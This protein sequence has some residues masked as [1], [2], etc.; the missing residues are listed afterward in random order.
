MSVGLDYEKMADKIIELTQKI[1]IYERT[2]K[3]NNTETKSFKDLSERQFEILMALMI[4]K[5]SSISEMAEIMYVSRSTLSI[6]VS[7][8]I[9]KGYIVKNIPED[10]M[11]KRKTIFSLSQ[12]GINCLYKFRQN[13]FKNFCILYNSFDEREKKLLEEGIDKLF[14][15][16]E[17]REEYMNDK[18]MKSDIIQAI[19]E[20]DNEL[21]KMNIK[22]AIFVGVF[23]K[24]SRDL[25]RNIFDLNSDEK[26]ITKNQ[27]YIMYCIYYFEHNTIS[28]LEKFLNS[29]GSTVS[30][31]V[32][33]LVTAGYLKK[34]YPKFN[35]DGRAVFIKL[36]N[37]GVKMLNMVHTRT[38]E[39]FINFIERLDEEG[40]QNFNSAI[41]CLLEVFKV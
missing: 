32:S 4:M 20:S 39:A 26:P 21:E 36:T 9:K 19:L 25:C 3:K 16:F 15:Y 29:S 17:F 18:F 14:S 24:A 5:K 7:K 38:K 13:N 27:F 35:D 28:K 23:F 41:D 22:M 37:K 11:D 2:C 8:L 30:I 6:I 10:G 12:E 31:T 1:P 34:S 40:V 33:R